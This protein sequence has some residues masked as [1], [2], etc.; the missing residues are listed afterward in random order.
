MIFSSDLVVL[1]CIPSPQCSMLSAPL[2]SYWKYLSQHF[3]IVPVPFSFLCAWACIG[4]IWCVT[5][6]SASILT[7]GIITSSLGLI[8]LN[9]SFPL[10]IP[11]C[12]F[13]MGGYRYTSY[14]NSFHQSAAFFEG[15]MKQPLSG[16]A[17]VM[18]YEHLTGKR[19]PLSLT[20]KIMSLKNHTVPA[21]STI[22]LYLA[23]KVM[24]VPGDEIRFRRLVCS[25]RAN[26]RYEKYLF[27]EGI[28]TSVYSDSFTYKRIR[29]PSY[30]V[31]RFFFQKRENIMKAFTHKLSPS[32]GILFSTLF[33]GGKASGHSQELYKYFSYWGIV[34]FLARSGLHITVLIVM[35]RSFFMY[36]RLPWAASQIMLFFMLT[37]YYLLSWPSISFIRACISWYQ[38][39]LFLG[40]TPPI[41]HIL[42]LTTLLVLL[43]NPYHLFFLDF[44]LSF[45]L[46]CALAWL[47]EA[48][49][50]HA[51]IGKTKALAEEK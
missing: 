20:I 34:H 1:I 45:G 36:L 26:T 41:L 8:W 23:N 18:G 24:L 5:T 31:R 21:R 22:T 44:Q 28:V 40:K 19:Y 6:T 11:L 43:N 15:Q 48:S 29:H 49:Y 42:S 50:Q 12:F 2:F 7:M 38:G 9:K 10:C 51:I 32:T 27:K 39:L 16:R 3:I 4:G 46:T 25:K 37:I 35:W 17:L 14:N 30:N 33:M 13:I 47:Q